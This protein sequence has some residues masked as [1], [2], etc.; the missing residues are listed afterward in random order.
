MS[1]KSESA[2][3]KPLAGSLVSFYTMDLDAAVKDTEEEG[4][5]GGEC[6]VASSEM[7]FVASHASLLGDVQV[8]KSLGSSLHLTEK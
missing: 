3:V 7:G 6:L 4:E 2:K 1:R 5:S 8:V